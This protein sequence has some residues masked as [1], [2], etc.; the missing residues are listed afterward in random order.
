[1]FIILLIIIIIITATT[2]TSGLSSH[3]EFFPIAVESHDPI[4]R[5]ALQFLS[6]LGS[7]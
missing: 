5:D 6:E 7:W 2:A 1:M 3:G 4:N